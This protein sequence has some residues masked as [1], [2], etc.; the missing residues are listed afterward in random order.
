MGRA[1][2]APKFVSSCD[3]RRR[4]KRKRRE[5]T[6]ADKSSKPQVITKEAKT[7]NLRVRKAEK[8]GKTREGKEKMAITKIGKSKSSGGA[9]DYVLKEVEDERKRAAKRVVEQ[10]AKAEQTARSAHVEQ[11]N[12]AGQT[13][14]VGEAVRAAEATNVG[15]TVMTKMLERV[16]QPEQVERAGQVEEAPQTPRY[17]QIEKTEWVGQ[18]EQ[19]R[20]IERAEK[21]QTSKDETPA[22]AKT[23][24][25]VTTNDGY[26]EAEKSNVGDGGEDIGRALKKP[27]IIGGNVRGDATQ[28]KGQFRAYELQNRR[29]T[30]TS[31]HIS[32]SFAENE[33]LSDKRAAEFGDKLLD[34]L[35]YKNTPR[36]IVRHSDKEQREESPY[37]H[38]HIVAGRID[39]NGVAVSDSKIAERAIAATNELAAEFGLKVTEYKPKREEKGLKRGELERARRGLPVTKVELQS[40]IKA[41]LQM[42][43]DVDASSVEKLGNDDKKNGEMAQSEKSQKVDDVEVLNA[44]KPN[45]EKQN[46]EKSN[47]ERSNIYEENV[48]GN[49]IRENGFYKIDVY[50]DGDKSVKLSNEATGTVSAEKTRADEACGGNTP[51]ARTKPTSKSVEDAL[52]Q[53]SDETRIDKNANEKQQTAVIAVRKVT[54]SDFAE[55]LE[56]LGVGVRANIDETSGELRGFAFDLNGTIMRGSSLGRA[57]SLKGLMEAGLDYDEQRDRGKLEAKNGRAN[58]SYIAFGGDG[59]SAIGGTVEN[60]DGERSANERVAGERIV[61]ERVTNSANKILNGGIGTGGVEKRTELYVSGYGSVGG[62][63]AGDSTRERGIEIGTGSIIEPERGT[64]I[65]TARI[66]ERAR[67]IRD[68]IR[69][70]KAGTG[71]DENTR[72]INGRRDTETDLG[73][74]GGNREQRRGN[75]EVELCTSGNESGVQQGRVEDAQGIQKNEGRNRRVGNQSSSAFG[76][77]ESRTNEDRRVER[78]GSKQLELQNAGNPRDVADSVDS[79]VNIVGVP[80]FKELRTNRL[81]SLT[82]NI[83]ADE[84]KDSKLVKTTVTILNLAWGGSLDERLL[85]G[86]TDILEKQ[87]SDEWRGFAESLGGA[88]NWGERVEMTTALVAQM[89]KI[90]NVEP[91]PIPRSDDE[92]NRMLTDFVVENTLTAKSLETTAQFENWLDEKLMLSAAKPPL[93]VQTASPTTTDEDNRVGNTQSQIAPLPLIISLSAA[94][95]P[96]VPE[97]RLEEN[98]LMVMAMNDLP[99]DKRT[100]R[101]DWLVEQLQSHFTDEMAKIE[102]RVEMPPKDVENNISMDFSMDF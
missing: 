49:V 73:V 75:V 30:N 17:G 40:A 102:T 48:D 98:A 43:L 14:K 94:T 58:A 36:L 79:D 61:G 11:V 96:P 95:S 81:K 37:E 63:V 22:T 84:K 100:A 19:I 83:G 9:I 77:F 21:A 33:R 38:I 4:Q 42:S 56:L 23:T 62:G 31:T 70:T 24:D 57:Y 46:I 7:E 6:A 25:E 32:I 66:I 5:S 67:T 12:E 92:R 50:A 101:A 93:N 8:A 44:E 47:V 26:A 54:A 59:K 80:D 28:I 60:D 74:E 64:G 52:S 99:D 15:Q 87:P 88:K 82:D 55:K 65:E 29:I 18:P 27:K 76:I 13:A 20:R 2:I 68:R 51:I 91:P 71:G 16:G 86:V 1:R 69:Q 78:T 10:A 89:A 85:S 39:E 97:T 45:V 35:G 90:T 41:C 53:A 72:I 3:E 34:K